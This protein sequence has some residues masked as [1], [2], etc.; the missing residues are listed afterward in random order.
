LRDFHEDVRFIFE[1]FPEALK[2]L[3][4]EIMEGIEKSPRI[5]SRSNE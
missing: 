1:C 5:E 2:L 3:N 4:L